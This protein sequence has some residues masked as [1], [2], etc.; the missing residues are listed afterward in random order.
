M[1][2]G[3]FFFLR[4]QSDPYRPIISTERWPGTTHALAESGWLAGW[5]ANGYTY[6]HKDGTFVV[7]MQ[8]LTAVLMLSAATGEARGSA[9]GRAR[10]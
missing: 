5:L 6:R 3:R 10:S 7:V 4:T 8:P 1:F 2:Y 9:N